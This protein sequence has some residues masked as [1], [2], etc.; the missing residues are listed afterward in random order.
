[1]RPDQ[2]HDR[3]Q[4][5][6]PAE[7][8]G[9]THSAPNVR[10]NATADLILGDQL[11]ERRHDQNG[12]DTI[13]LIAAACVLLS[14]SYPIATGSNDQEPL[15]MLTRGQAT[16][17]GL[18]VGAFFVISGLLISNSFEVSTSAASFARKRAIRIM[19]AL[20]VVCIV[21]VSV[22]G[23]LATTLPVAAY[24]HGAWRFMA[25]AVFVPAGFDLP[26]VFKNHPMDAVNGSLWSLKFEVICYLGV[27]AFLALKRGRA[28]I[29]VCAWVGS[30][31]VSRLLNS[32]EGE[33]GAFFYIGTLAG[34]FRFFGAGMVLYLFRD[35]VRL[36]RGAAW[37]A[38][39]VTVA[40]IATP[41]FMEAAAT[42]GVYALVVFGYRCPAWFRRITA[43]GDISYG[44]YLYAFPIQQVLFGVAGPHPWLISAIALPLTLLVAVL[45]WVLVERPAMRLKKRLPTTRTENRSLPTW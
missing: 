23:P 10:G 7:L 33:A 34:L 17:G 20:I 31:L 3:N 45:S 11:R 43:R 18:S 41:F 38:F 24:F 42:A 12:F 29:V 44:T 13:R 26:G 40:S 32:G 14:H 25:H 5:V 15:T 4:E 35:R 28:A 16:V 21:L 1:M 27:A 19:P 2:P 9:A 37:V 36:N 8:D 22:L 6:S 30:F 39:L